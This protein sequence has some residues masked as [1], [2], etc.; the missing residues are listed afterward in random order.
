MLF[1]LFLVCMA[2]V[3]KLHAGKKY[4]IEF[5]KRKYWNWTRSHH[6]GVVRVVG[7]RD[8][9]ELVWPKPPLD[10]QQVRIHPRFVL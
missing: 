5:E 1:Q 10:V 8:E 9:G 7:L 3:M 2:S 4:K 6:M